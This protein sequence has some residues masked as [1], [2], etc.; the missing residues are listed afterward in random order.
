MQLFDDLVILRIVL[1]TTA[2]IDHRGDPE[3]VEL[4]HEM[5]SGVGLVFQRQA[6]AFGQACVENQRVGLGQQQTRWVAQLVALDAPAR[7]I[8]GGLVVA[9]GS[10]RCAIE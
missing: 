9:A 2:G 6:R 8:R 10:Q 7:R 4:A 3:P 5:A 1:E